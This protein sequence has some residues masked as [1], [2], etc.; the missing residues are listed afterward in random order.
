MH[1]L[2]SVLPIMGDTCRCS[3]LQSLFA[4]FCI[5][6]LA[7]LLCVYVCVVVFPSFLLAFVFRFPGFSPPQFCTVFGS[8]LT[9]YRHVRVLLYCNIRFKVD[10]T[11]HKTARGKH[12]T[13]RHT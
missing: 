3:S 9:D 8:S 5:E 2:R 1:L 13:D 7:E 10:K 11:Q 12:S 4:S 6:L